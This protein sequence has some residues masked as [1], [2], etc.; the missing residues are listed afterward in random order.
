VA[1][2]R[3]GD[4]VSLAPFLALSKAL[5]DPTRVRIL[6][7]LTRD[8]LCLCQIVELFGL[9]PS[10][11]SKH[12]DLLSTAGLVR[13]RKQGRWHYFRLAGEAAPDEVRQALEWALGAVRHDRAIREDA[14][15]LRTILRK[16]LQETAACYRN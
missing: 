13:R 14:K 3:S 15:R 10:T 1:K 4:A 7:A 5:S 6:A 11:L 12:V 16:D 8:E 2:Y 9:A